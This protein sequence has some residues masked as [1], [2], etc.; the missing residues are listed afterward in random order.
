VF[1]PLCSNQNIT[2][3]PSCILLAETVVASRAL[4]RSI[5]QE[6]RHLLPTSESATTGTRLCLL[7]GQHGQFCNCWPWPSTRRVLVL[8]LL[9]CSRHMK[10]SAL[11]AFVERSDW[12]PRVP[13][14]NN[15]PFNFLATTTTPIPR[16]ATTQLHSARNRGGLEQRREGATP[17][18]SNALFRCNVLTRP[19]F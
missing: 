14:R 13:A 3:T 16:I 6:S 1:A 2:D 9:S 19:I 4:M 10:T 11:Q 8:I 7:N 18:G 12:H 5:S 17:Q 15:L